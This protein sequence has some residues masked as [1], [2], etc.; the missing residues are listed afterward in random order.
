MTWS[1][2]RKLP[3][4]FVLV[5]PLLGSC[6]HS[7]EPTAKQQAMD[8]WNKARSTVLIGLA[9]DQYSNGNFDKSRATVDEAVKLEP[10]NL[11]AH[12]LSSKL[13]IETGQLEAAE[14]ELEVA[15]Q[16]D[17]K[18]AQADYLLGVV[19]QRWQ[20]PEKALGF[21]Q[22]AYE[23]SPAELAYVIARA[24]MLVA[25]DR[26]PEALALLESKV[27]YFEHSGA[28]RD[29]V[30]LLLLQ[31]KK[32]PEAVEMLRRASILTPD[33]MTIRE[34]LGRALYEEKE[35]AEASRVLSELVANSKYERRGD[36]LMML[37]ECQLQTGHSAGAVQ[38]LQRASELL[39]DSAGVWISLARADVQLSSF[40]R[41]ET[42]LRQA[43]TLDANSGEAWLLLGFVQLQEA[44]VDEA[45]DSFDRAVRINPDDTVSLC[46]LGLSLDE[47]GRTRQ[48]ATYFER[49]LEIHPG[50]A[51][52][53]ELMARLEAHE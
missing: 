15:Q 4:I 7:Q 8:R 11:A 24:E 1:S 28:I 10:M 32:Y 36:L 19:Y 38:N 42:A 44:R 41:A 46:M 34:H 22:S 37:G 50:D 5:I 35:Y 6:S 30:G 45:S 21:Y 43:L 2:M 25:L 26:R 18:D 53:T 3:L 14:R 48:A 40:H 33:D 16:V 20:Q 27:S 13:Y 49:A 12:L 31:E 23:K 47:L 29:E 39:P 17:P 9:M 51:M 52:A